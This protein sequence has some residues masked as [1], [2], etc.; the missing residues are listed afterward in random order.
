MQRYRLDFLKERAQYS[1]RMR[2]FREALTAAMRELERLEGALEVL[3][4][5]ETRYALPMPTW[6]GH[7]QR[8]YGVRGASP[9]LKVDC[10]VMQRS[11]KRG[12][13]E[14]ERHGEPLVH[15]DHG[16]FVKAVA[17]DQEALAASLPDRA[18]ELAVRF[19]MFQVLTAKELKRG[20]DLE[21][22]AFYHGFTLRP[23]VSLLRLVHAPER[24]DFHTRYIHHDLPGEW[25]ET[26][27]GLFFVSDA[28][29]LERRRAEAERLFVRV[30]REAFPSVGYS[31]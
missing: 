8:F 9:Y 29:D 11:D 6:H 20:Q 30:L 26:L 10:V 17:M 14:R 12:L 22:I 3:A 4:G 7:A 25:V 23:L 2:D 5:I 16:G 21:A 19:A 13:D 24:H 15:F 18:R 27:R 1:G 28:E 31:P